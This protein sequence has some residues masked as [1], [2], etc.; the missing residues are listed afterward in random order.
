MI[1]IHR[2]VFV[3]LYFSGEGEREKRDAISHRER[4]EERLRLLIRLRRKAFHESITVRT[5]LEK[6]KKEEEEEVGKK[7]RFGGTG[8]CRR[9]C[10][11]SIRRQIPN[12]HTY[13]QCICAYCVYRRGPGRHVI[14]YSI[15]VVVLARSAKGKEREKEGQMCADGHKWRDS[16]N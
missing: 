7:K 2:A 15:R 10:W 13:T 6:K 14:H 5:K 4:E 3:S 16:S 9:C 1:T 12:A 8:C 11:M